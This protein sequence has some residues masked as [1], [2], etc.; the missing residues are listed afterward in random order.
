MAVNYWGEPIGQLTIKRHQYKNGEV[1]KDDK[2]REVY[3]K[4]KIQI[5]QG[6]CLAVFIYAYK[7][8]GQWWHQLY[9]FFGDEQHIKN[10][11]K[12]VG[13]LFDDEVAGVK[14][15]MY[16]KECNTLLKYFVREGIRVQCYYKEPKKK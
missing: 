7:K 5:R 10:I 14:L 8:D 15:N 6:N 12:N 3:E 13:D 11:K 2:G 9:T 1:V 16:Y 4:F